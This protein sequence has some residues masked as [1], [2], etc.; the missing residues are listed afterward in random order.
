MESVI[1]PK[2]RNTT[3]AAASGHEFHALV[4]GSAR[5]RRLSFDPRLL[6]CLGQY[7]QHLPT[8]RVRRTAVMMEILPP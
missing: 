5:D 4:G 2:D 8:R 3:D 6:A 7:W 1:A